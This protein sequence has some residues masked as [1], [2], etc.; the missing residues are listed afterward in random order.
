MSIHQGSI[1]RML[2]IWNERDPGRHAALL[3]AALAPDILFI[4]PTIRTQGLAEFERNV[5]HF[6]SKYPEAKVRRASAI[7]SHHDLHRYRWEIEMHGKVQLQGLDIAETGPDGK[8]CKVL[9]FFG[10]LAPLPA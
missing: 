8:V 2:S 4:D 10:P 1:D 5:R 7:D 3:E 9:G 6:H